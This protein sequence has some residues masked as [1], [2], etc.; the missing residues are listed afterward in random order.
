MTRDITL[1]LPEDLA[2]E[3]EQYG[4]LSSEQ[5]ARLIQD[6]IRKRKWKV[7]LATADRLAEQDL[8]PSTEDELEAE[9]A[10]TRAERRA[11]HANRS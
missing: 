9:I 3:A 4:L 1:Q 7:L 5:V 11:K 8:P 6:E 10:A 2:S